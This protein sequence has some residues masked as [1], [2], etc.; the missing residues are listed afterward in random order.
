[1]T[2]KKVMNSWIAIKP[3]KQ[4]NNTSFLILPDETKHD[5]IGYEVGV[6]TMMPDFVSYASPNKNT[7]A[8]VIDMKISQTLIPSDR[9]SFKVGD[10]VMYRK[11]LSGIHQHED[12]S[13]IFW[14]DLLAIVPKGSG[15]SNL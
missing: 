6:I 15:I 14:L 11:Y 7:E 8:Q 1:M 12:I 5:K 4:N 2:I 3:E 10:R 9:L 13:F